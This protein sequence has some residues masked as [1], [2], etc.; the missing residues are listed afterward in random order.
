MERYDNM[1][2]ARNRSIVI[3]QNSSRRVLWLIPDTET[4]LMMSKHMPIIIAE[5]DR[6]WLPILFLGSFCTM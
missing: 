5:V 6:I 2:E 1:Q 4:K 3:A